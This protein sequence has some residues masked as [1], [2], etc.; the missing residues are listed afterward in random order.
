MASRT[1]QE[2]ASLSFGYL[3]FML[4]PPLIQP[5]PVDSIQSVRKGRVFSPPTQVA[6]LDQA[7][8]RQNKILLCLASLNL[9]GQMLPDHLTKSGGFQCSCMA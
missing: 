7:A 8:Y 4:H 9:V 1:S 6:L 5:R 2:P 3:R